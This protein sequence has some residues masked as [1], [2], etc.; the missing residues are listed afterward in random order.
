MLAFTEWLRGGRQLVLE[1]SFRT[2]QPSLFAVVSDRR[3]DIEAEGRGPE[4]WVLDLVS[5]PCRLCK[6]ESR[7]FC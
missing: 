6:H 3:L 5:G 4:R 7:W 1:P 2:M